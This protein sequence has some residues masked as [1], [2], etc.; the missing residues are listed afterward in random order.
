MSAD[1]CIFRAALR[2][3]A[4]PKRLIIAALLIC[5]PVGIALLIRFKRGDRFE[6]LPV[7]NTLTPVFVFGFI[8]VILSVVFATGAISQ[9]VEQKT[10]VYLL[11]RPIARW[12]LLL[13]KFAAA[14]IVA[15]ATSWVA[16]TCLALAVLGPG[17]ILHS[18][19]THDLSII[20]VG[21][22]AYGAVFL[23]LSTV[24]N[25]PLL[26]GLLY[27]FGIETW[28]SYVPGLQKVSLMYYLHVLAP[29]RQIER[30][31]VNPQELVNALSP[32]AVSVPIS[33][34]VLIFAI[35]ASLLMA[36]LIFS[37]NEYV[38]REDAD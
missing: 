10:I 32:V 23:L 8:L 36:L 33:W 35:F 2:D 12:R 31:S 6:P 15:T 9:E 3:L 5:V 16:L 19:Y 38:P 26:W 34:G 37:N 13:A 18:Q 11:T 22:L 28:T 20:P 14:V 25:R 30:Q 24:I 7:Y 17:K 4:K 27:A 21:A 29:H 1:L